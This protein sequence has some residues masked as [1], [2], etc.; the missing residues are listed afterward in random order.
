MRRW[1]AGL[2]L[3][4]LLGVTAGVAV[5]LVAEDRGRGSE[6]STAPTVQ[7]TPADPAVTAAPD[8]ALADFYNQRLTWSACGDNRCSTLTVPLDYAH[9][10]ERSIE[11]R[12]LKVPA[13]GQRLGSLVVNP[14]G[15][16]A[17]GTEYAAQAASVFGKPLL[18]HFDIVGF[19]P[20]GTGESSPVDCLDD[21]QL[22]DFLA[23]DPAPSTVSETRVFMGGVRAFGQGCRALSGELAAHVSTEDAARDMDVLRAALGQS[24]LDYFGAS[25]GTKL[26]AVYAD[27]FPDKVGRLVLDG[28]MDLELS[29]RDLS[30]QQAAG[31]QTA[32]D[33]YL[34]DC[35]DNTDQ[36]CFLGNSVAEGRRTIEDLLDRIAQNPLPTTSD[37]ELTLGLAFY[38]IATPLYNKDYWF[39]LTTGLKSA[40]GGDGSALLLLAD[41]Y[42]YRNPS[43]GFLNNAIEANLAINCRDDGWSLPATR[44]PTQVPAFEKAS[45]VFGR[46]FAWSL[47]GCRGF[48]WPVA[49]PYPKVMA[50]G[51]APILVIGTSRDPATPLAWA[52]ALADQLASG[53]LVT[54]D[55]DGHT[56][57]HAGNACVDDA[58]EDYLVDGDVPQDGLAC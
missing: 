48:G 34:Q 54:R 45:P 16:G 12:L 21:D 57:Y 35:I 3:L 53:V 30:L 19:D 28:A 31:F 7:P 10:G 58:V 46:I 44:V 41:A 5:T 23:A 32:L 26:G 6:N 39:M 47:T 17:P 2:V 29:T 1:I 49:D 40:I 13:R 8:P 42:A 37:R 51:A 43:G 9:P 33:A 36:S 20:R 15:P 27:L 24:T 22:D 11:L 4:G 56:G 14:G 55:G 25:Y 50:K 38:G 18:E 52:K